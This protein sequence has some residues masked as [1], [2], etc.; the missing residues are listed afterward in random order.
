MEFKHIKTSRRGRVLTFTLDRPEVLNAF[1]AA[2]H[3]DLAHAFVDAASDPHSDVIV[4]TGNGRAFSA[5]GDL[6]W[7][8]DAIDDPESFEVTV[9]E[10]K[11]IVFSMLDCEKPIIAR[12]NGPAV[13]FGATIALLSD[14]SIIARSTYISDPHVNVG[15][16]AGDGA[17]VIWPQLI[18]YA[19]AKEY[20]FLGD[21]IGAEEAER[22]GLVN[23]V[24][25]DADLDRA[26]DDLADR[27]LAGAQ[28]AIRWTKLSINIPL[29]ELASSMMD[30]SLAYESLTNAS[31]DHARAVKAFREKRKVRFGR[32]A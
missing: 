10:A 29:R 12:I 25:D 14:L 9:R 20:L 15:M 11:Q 23:H 1:N 16:V 26:V 24:V 19:R 31:E 18:G 22:I 13:G 27:L 5:G 28:K 30:A 4:L 2:M 8:Q 17:A 32:E 21:R 7:Q 3:T 6:D